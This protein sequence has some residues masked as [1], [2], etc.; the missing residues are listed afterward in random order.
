MRA[1]LAMAV[2]L[3]AILPM[4]CRS[5][6][7]EGGRAER[8]APGGAAAVL[9]GAARTAAPPAPAFELIDQ[10][11]KTVRLSDF[12]GK[13]VVLEWTNP[14]CPYVQRHYRAG[15]MVRL[16]EKY[17]DRGVAWLAINT[18][19]YFDRQKNAEW[20]GRQKL[21]YPVLDDSD[22]RVGKAY[23]AKTTPH[24]YVVDGSGALVY[25]GAIDDDSA[26]KRGAE[27]ANYVDT[28]LTDLLAGKA[29][30]V[31]QTRPYGCSVKYGS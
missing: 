9:A 6:P 31:S 27:A 17:R 29:P 11:G 4:A 22:G 24:M 13:I 30:R 14:D 20:H 1:S 26:G 16:A 5:S 15:T 25:A 19:D 23:G 3:L 8:D 10:D 18:T 7:D 21:P 2:A 28:V 12:A